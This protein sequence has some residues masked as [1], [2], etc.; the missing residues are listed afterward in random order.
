MSPAGRR[1]RRLALVA[2]GVLGLAACASTGAGA[3]KAAHDDALTVFAAASLRA[4]FERI[5]RDVEAAHP[6]VRVAFTF[7]GSADLVAQLDA[8]APGDVLATADETDMAK[9]VHAGVVA[10]DASAVFATN[11]LTVV[12]PPGNPAKVA[13]FADL[14][15]PGVRAVV[16]APQ[17]PCGRATE[18][19]ERAAGVTL[20]PVSEENSVT[21]VLG[22]VT[23]GQADAGV[24]YVTDARRAGAKVTTVTVPQAAAVVNA[25]PIAATSAGRREL[26]AEFVAHVRGPAGRKV[27]AEAGFGA[28]TP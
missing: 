3:G 11:T 1:P 10:A 17:V 19:V 26:A 15:R 9:A 14:A 16:C 22:K 28:P 24:V 4:P 7:A 12:T 23:S 18:R 21:D 5:G 6:G 8:G 13:S 2:V 27:L 25:Y 20:R